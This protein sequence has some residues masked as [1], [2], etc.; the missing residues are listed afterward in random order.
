MLHCGE[1][2]RGVSEAGDTARRRRATH[3]P[4]T[5]EPVWGPGAR[6]TQ[7]A[8]AALTEFRAKHLKTKERESG[9]SRGL[10]SVGKPFRDAP[11]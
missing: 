2:G 11:F 9:Q 6:D 5:A 4:S 7:A 1:T 10:S 8:G 3:R